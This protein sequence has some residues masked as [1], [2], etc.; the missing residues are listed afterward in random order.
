MRANLHPRQVNLPDV[1]MACF[2]GLSAEIVDDDTLSGWNIVTGLWEC[3]LVLRGRVPARE[4]L[5]DFLE[6]LKGPR[7]T[8]AD[9]LDESHC[10]DFHQRPTEVP[11]EF[12][13]TTMGR[14]VFQAKYRGNAAAADDIATQMG[15]FINRHRRYQRAQCTAAV[16]R[17]ISTGWLNLAQRLIGRLTGLLAKQRVV[18][19]R[20]QAVTSQK[21]VSDEAERY[22]RQ[23]G[24]MGCDEDLVGQSVVV[25]DDM[26]GSGASMQEAARAL[27]AV[28]ATEVLGLAATKTLKYARG[29]SL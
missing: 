25:I 23:Q 26:Y 6:L 7:I 3:D 29:V 5:A 17:S 22:S 12:A 10:L 19:Y 9:K 4:S 28:G 13:Y 18:L 11:Q 14:L 8:I 15:G 1:L 21:D 24:T 2:P 20:S 16:P 27:R